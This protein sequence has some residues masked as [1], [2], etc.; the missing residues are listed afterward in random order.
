MEVDHK[1]EIGGVSAFDGDWNVMIAKIMPRPVSEHLQALCIPCHMRKTR[2][3]MNAA[4]QWERK[5]REA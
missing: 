4:V 2:N 1:V 5:K 3:F